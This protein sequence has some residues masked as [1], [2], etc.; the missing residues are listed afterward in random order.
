MYSSTYLTMRVHTAEEAAEVQPTETVDTLL[1]LV[2][3]WDVGGGCEAAVHEQLMQKFHVE[4]ERVPGIL[5]RW[6]KT[7]LLWVTLLHCRSS[8]TPRHTPRPTQ[9]PETLVWAAAQNLLVSKAEPSTWSLDELL[10]ALDVLAQRWQTMVDSSELRG[11]MGVLWDLACHWTLHRFRKGKWTSS[12]LEPVR[13]TEWL[14]IVPKAIMSMLSRYY[15]FNQTLQQLLW[16][17]ETPYT[18]KPHHF[19]RFMHKQK[20]HLKIR[21]FRDTLAT[22]VWESLL[23]Y[24]D[25]EIATHDQLGDILSAYS[26]LY[27]RQPICLM[28]QYQH[29]LAYGTYEEICEHFADTLWLQMAQSYFVNNY[30]LDFLKFFVCLEHKQHRHKD[31]LYNMTVPIVLQRFGRYTVLHEGATHGL[32]SVRDVFPIWVALA[33]K[34]HGID[35]SMLKDELFSEQVLHASVIEITAL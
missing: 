2:D 21:K 6:T 26:C 25:S 14:T 5:P 16:F 19:D 23:L 3:T 29:M 17:P 24:G 4:Q 9:R 30:Q 22:A 32:G 15:W 10:L 18:C 12:A 13:D 8:D 33:D 20:R 28:Q 27:K 31:A 1:W 34:P 7:M 35:L 11:Y